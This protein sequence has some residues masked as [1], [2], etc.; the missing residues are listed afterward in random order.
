MEPD[1]LYQDV[2]EKYTRYINP[3]LARLM[4]F[5]GFG[6]EMRGEGCYIYDQE[7][8]QYLDCLGGYGTFTFGHRNPKVIEAVKRQLDEMPL[9]GKAFFN[10]QTANLAEKLAEIA[11]GDLK[12]SFFC[13]SG[14]EAVEACLKMAKGATQRIKIVSTHGSYHGKTLGALA[15]TGREK[16]R[17]KFEPLMPGVEFVDYG[18]IEQLVNAIDDHTACFIVEPIQGEG[19][20]IV[21]PDGYLRAA[22]EA[23]DRHGALLIFD[24]V[25][26]GLGRAGYNFACE[27]EGVAPDMM[28]LAKAIGGGVMPL[29]VAMYTEDIYHKIFG[30]NPMAHTSTFGGN[31]LACAA[32]LAALEILTTENLGENSRVLGKHMLEGFQAIQAKFPDLLGEVRGRGLMIGVEFTMDEVGEVVVAQLMKHGVCVA[33][34]LN[35]PRVLRF[36]PPLVISLEQVNHALGAFEAGLQE[37]ADLLALLA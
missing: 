27:H 17:K 1:A 21:P 35:N 8:R 31:P 11:P 4:G 5:A 33:Y 18:S 7:G 6:V 19:G 26:S 34:A 32:G 22:R 37:T 29:G 30:D 20:I 15:T 12:F 10:A 36:E 2:Y 13:N 3:N 9:S 25:Q 23:C 28:P 16:Y 14:A 24:E